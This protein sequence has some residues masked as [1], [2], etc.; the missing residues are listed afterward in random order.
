MGDAKRALIVLNCGLS[1][2]SGM[3]RAMQYQPLFQ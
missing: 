3:V 1:D 2:P